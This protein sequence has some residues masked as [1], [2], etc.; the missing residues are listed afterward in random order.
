MVIGLITSLG[1][2]PN[3]LLIAQ[4]RILRCVPQ[5]VPDAESAG[6]TPPN[7]HSRSASA[8]IRRCV[9]II[10]CSPTVANPIAFDRQNCSTIPS[11]SGF[12]RARTR[13][14]NTAV[15]RQGMIDAAMITGWKETR[16]V[17]TPIR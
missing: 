15:A 2:G 5:P 8:V 6:G 1:A 7:H 11:G 9:P 4:I 3:P 14:T 10:P 13:E 16:S 12:L 17:I